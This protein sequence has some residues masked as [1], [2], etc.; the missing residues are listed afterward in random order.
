MHTPT[1]TCV[2]CRKKCEKCGLI[3]ITCVD[4]NPVIDQNK[5]NPHRAIY[6]CKDDKCISLLQKNKAIE[7]FLKVKANNEFYDIL[8]EFAKREK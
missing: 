4:D 8:K 1:R 6:V 3:R 2:S 7:R 5:T